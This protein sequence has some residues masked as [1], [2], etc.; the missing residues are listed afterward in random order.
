LETCPAEENRRFREDIM[1]WEPVAPLLYVWDYTTDFGHYQQPFPN[2][3]A[4]QSNVRFF[5]KHGVK[6]L[7]EQ[8][9]YSGGGAGEM[10][11]LRVYILAKLLWNP[12][13]D[14]M[15][16]TSEFLAAY[17]GKAA[18]KLR[19]YLNIIHEPVRLGAR[20]V[21]IFDK[22]SAAYLTAETM[23]AAEKALDEAEA[24]AETEEYR[25]RVQTARLPVWYV[26][27]A[28]KSFPDDSRKELAKRFMV[29]ARK[30]G[31]SN[32][33]EGQALDVWAKKVGAE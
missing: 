1:A 6:S 3:D 17:Y 2:F 32:I 25:F 13:S 4:L 24:T 7:F 22:P 26:R 31:I 12:D 14:V 28:N 16:H 9:N 23:A 30:A 27:I 10:E 11:P 15:K 19:E 5:V 21:H 29:V 33:S 8:G 20:H 18:P